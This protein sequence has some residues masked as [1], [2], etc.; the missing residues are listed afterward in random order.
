MV[1]KRK[2]QAIICTKYISCFRNIQRYVHLRSSHRAT[3]G[4]FPSTSSLKNIL[5]A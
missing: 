1:F 3:K 2:I 5:T 4:T